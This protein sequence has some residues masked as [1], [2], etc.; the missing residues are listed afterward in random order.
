MIAAMTGLSLTLVPVLASAANGAAVRPDVLSILESKNDALFA[1]LAAQSEK[2]K[3]RYIVVFKQG[4]DQG[5][6]AEKHGFV[7]SRVFT[8]ALNGFAADLNADQ[9]QMLK[10]NKDV[11]YVEEDFVVQAFAQPKSNLDWNDFFN[12]FKKSSSSSSSSKSSVASSS[13]RSSVVSSPSSS[14]A[15]SLSSQSSVSSAVSSAVS[16]VSSVPPS[17]IPSN[18]AVPTGINRIDA[19]LSPTAAI[20]GTPNNLDVDVA[21]V[22]TGVDLDHPDLNVFRNVNM[23][24]SANGDD[25]NGHGTHVAGTIGAKDDGKGVVGVAPGARIWAVKVLDSQGSGLMSDIIAGVDYVAQHADEI[26]VAN[27]SLGCQCTSSA[28]DNA[29]NNAVK[30]GVTVV[31]AAGNNAKDSSNFSPAKNPNVITVS[32]VADFNG[33]GGGGAAST[34][35]SDVD[36]SFANFSNYGVPV[37]IA[38]PGVCITSTYTGGGTSIMSGTSMASPHVAG[39]AALW[40]AGHGRQS[41]ASVKSALLSA[42]IAQSAAGGFSED[43]DGAKE[44]MLNVKGY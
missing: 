39:A 23:I 32:A 4:A 16:S 21:V 44:P 31:V 25:D 22:D 11:A 12:R 7:R 5:D 37:D 42:A 2:A 35:R 41:P 14:S 33:Q 3:G 24:T 34:C 28:L 19:E 17:S 1:H 40:M 43:P 27:L 36:D 15:V 10:N 20:D 30:A 18:V 6:V 13:S 8:K 38:A 26:E 29:L 9:L